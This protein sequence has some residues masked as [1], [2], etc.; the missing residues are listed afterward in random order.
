MND[1]PNERRNLAREAR[2]IRDALD[3]L[4]ALALPIRKRLRPAARNEV[5]ELTPTDSLADLSIDAMF[6]PPADVP[7][8]ARPRPPEDAP[9]LDR[10]VSLA[11]LDDFFGDLD[12]PDP[13]AAE[14]PPP[15]DPSADAFSPG[16][17]EDLFEGFESES[18]ISAKV[19]Q[20]TLS[21]TARPDMDDTPPNGYAP[22]PPQP[23]NPPKAES[24]NDVLDGFEW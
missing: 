24:I 20:E 7:A 15:E 16:T 13:A 4:A 23:E 21:F 19:G 17:S 1:L 10:S 18:D 2:K 12:I 14:D 22:L 8:P 5:P 6:E 3:E 11:N 9:T